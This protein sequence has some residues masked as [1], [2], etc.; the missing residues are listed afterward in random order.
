MIDVFSYGDEDG[1]NSVT[2]KENEGWIHTQRL[3]FY[4]GSKK[5]DNH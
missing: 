3:D 5:L 2:G 1:Y 4:G